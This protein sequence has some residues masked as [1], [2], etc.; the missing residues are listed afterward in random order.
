MTRLEYQFSWWLGD[1]IVEISLSL[2]GEEWIEEPLPKW[3]WLRFTG[4]AHQ[5]DLGMDENFT[6][7]VSERALA[8]LREHGLKCADVSRAIG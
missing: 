8:V 4:K 1:A 5:E 7:V 3:K 6:L 2:E